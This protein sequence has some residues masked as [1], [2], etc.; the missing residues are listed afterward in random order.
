[1][2]LGKIIDNRTSSLWDFYTEC[3]GITDHW[4][5]SDKGCQ[6]GVG[7][8]DDDKS[9]CSALRLGA[10]SLAIPR[11][12]G[13]NWRERDAYGWS[14]SIEGLG[15]KMLELSDSAV[16]YAHF[17]GAHR[18]CLTRVR[19]FIRYQ[20]RPECCFRPYRLQLETNT[21]KSHRYHEECDTKPHWSHI[22]FFTD[23]HKTPILSEKRIYDQLRIEDQVRAL[24]VNS[25]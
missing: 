17:T 21:A 23:H 14:H 11:L 13:V 15:R 19:E 6:A 1:M 18:D 25:P 8:T 20:V 7:T 10:Y 16:N 9:Q 22:G 4:Y 5:I 3:T 2:T 24:K 12:F